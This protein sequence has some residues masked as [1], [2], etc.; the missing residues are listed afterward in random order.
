MQ[1]VR[2]ECP[3]GY[4]QRECR[5]PQPLPG[6]LGAGMGPWKTPASLGPCASLMLLSARAEP[7]W[8]SRGPGNAATPTPGIQF[9]QVTPA[10]PRPGWP[11]SKWTT[12]GPRAPDGAR[13][14]G[15]LCS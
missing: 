10:P 5:Y 13:A 1:E 6:C 14:S 7:S 8:A 3:L 4:C 12:R 9:P 2:A 15:N 11:E